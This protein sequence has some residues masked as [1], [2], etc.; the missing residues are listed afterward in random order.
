MTKRS[1]L[2]AKKAIFEAKKAIF[3]AKGV[4][5]DA[6][7]ADNSRKI[8]KNHEGLFEFGVLRLRQ[9]SAQGP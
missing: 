4:M 7:E 6:K 8:M 3:E 2:E 1:I 5:L 9:W